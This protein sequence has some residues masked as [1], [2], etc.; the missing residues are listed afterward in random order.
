ML[1]FRWS[2][3]MLWKQSKVWKSR[4]DQPHP[5]LTVPHFTSSCIQTS[6]SLISLHITSNHITSHSIISFHGTSPHYTHFT[7]CQPFTLPLLVPIFPL[8]LLMQPS[9]YTALQF[10]SNTHLT[11]CLV[12]LL[13]MITCITAHGMYV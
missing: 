12:C 9:P 10:T 11:Q 3:E 2:L 4:L 7:Q 13:Y 1:A 5:L 6:S 8:S